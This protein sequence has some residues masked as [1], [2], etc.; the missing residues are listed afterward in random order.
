MDKWKT[1]ASRIALDHPWFRVRKDTVELPNGMVL[2]DYTVWLDREVVLIVP[3]TNEGF[4]VFVRQYKHGANDIMIEF[5]AGYV[6][7]DEPL[8]EAAKRELE[9]ETGY[10]VDTLTKI[11]QLAHNPTKAIGSIHVFMANQLPTARSET[12]FDETEQIELVQL[13]FPDVCCKI[14][15]GEI[16]SSGTIAAFH[17][18]SMKL[19]LLRALQ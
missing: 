11:G 19:E 16:Y 3:I 2:D 9:E 8:M 5:P 10:R 7:P 17:L 12:R 18:A 15:Q 13:S 14:D 4:F 6:D 1:L